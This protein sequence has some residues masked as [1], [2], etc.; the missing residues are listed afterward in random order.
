MKQII[1]SLI[2]LLLFCSCSQSDEPTTHLPQ[3]S[4]DQLNYT[5]GKTKVSIKLSAQQA[6]KTDLTVPVRFT[7]DAKMGEDFEVEQP[8]FTLKAGQ[9]SALLEIKRKGEVSENPKKVQIALGQAPAGYELGLKNYCMLKL[10]GN[11]GFLLNF[12]QAEGDLG[13]VSSFGIRIDGI[14]E[15]YR[16]MTTSKFAIEVDPSSTAVRGVHFELLDEAQ[17]IVPRKRNRG[18]FKVKFLKKEAGKDKIVL[19]FAERDGFASGNNDKMTITIKGPVDIAGDWKLTQIANGKWLE[20]PNNYF[21][22]KLDELINVQDGDAIKLEGDAFKYKLI[23]MFKGKLK[24]FF[25]GES[26][27]VI[28]SSRED[29]LQESTFEKITLTRYKT[30]GVNVLFSPS[31]TKKRPALVDFRLIKDENGKE[32]LECTLADFEPTTKDT[33]TWKALY[34]MMGSMEWTPIRLHFERK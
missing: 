32:I 19:R 9:K 34:E 15:R 30:E 5:L 22:I 8:A 3:L 6:P 11:D 14:K 24:N 26:E 20:D 2:G 16:L 31:E 23:P 27:L 21:G 33:P 13:F 25:I 1:T 29:T 10:L 18:A 12:A 7:G 28:D 17:A 4:I